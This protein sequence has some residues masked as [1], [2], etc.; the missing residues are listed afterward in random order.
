[1]KLR[2]EWQAAIWAGA[3]HHDPIADAVSTA[4]MSLE[5]ILTPHLRADGALLPAAVS[6][7]AGK[8][9]F[10]SRR[11]APALKPPKANAS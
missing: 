8:A 7:C 10:T 3:A 5:A 1:V 6:W 4:Q 2:E 9:W 11:K